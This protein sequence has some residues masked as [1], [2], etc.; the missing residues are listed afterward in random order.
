MTAF[1]LE[2]N[3]HTAA[4][5]VIMLQH[6]IAD[7]G[8]RYLRSLTL[9]ILY[10]GNSASPLSICL[11]QILTQFPCLKQL[12][13]LNIIFKRGNGTNM[14]REASSSSITHYN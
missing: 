4:R 14:I 6:F 5:A 13:L 12:A 9:S 1:H 2:V 11:E 7:L 8:G 3:I 10:G